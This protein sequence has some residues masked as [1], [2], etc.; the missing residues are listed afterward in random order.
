MPMHSGLSSI[1]VRT[2]AV[3]PSPLAPRRTT[4]HHEASSIFTVPR[5]NM[6]TRRRFLHDVSAAGA[7]VGL[8]PLMTPLNAQRAAAPTRAP[9]R[10]LIL[11]G[12]GFLGPH[13]VHVLTQR[14]HRVSMLNRGRRE[15]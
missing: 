4:P 1:H 13:L 3:R 9:L 7:M 2:H 14:G 10:V 11:G 5:A 8:A 6:R 15:P 12:T